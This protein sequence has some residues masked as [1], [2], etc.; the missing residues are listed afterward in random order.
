LEI[1]DSRNF[2]FLAKFL[3]RNDF[4]ISYQFFKILHASPEVNRINQYLSMPAVSHSSNL[5]LSLP[6]L[7][8]FNLKSTPY[9]ISIIIKIVKTSYQSADVIGTKSVFGKP[10]QNAWL[11]AIMIA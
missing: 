9:N 10:Q 5:I 6:N 4:C 11:S 8:V 3:F 2:S 7:I 1:R